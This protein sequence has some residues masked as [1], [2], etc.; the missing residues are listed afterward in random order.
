MIDELKIYPL[1]FNLNTKSLHFLERIH[2]QILSTIKALNSFTKKK[3][4]YEIG[5][6]IVFCRKKRN[7]FLPDLCRKGF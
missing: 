6:S 3:K 1:F 5:N 7:I 4:I 2:C